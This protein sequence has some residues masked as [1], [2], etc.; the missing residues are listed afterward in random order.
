MS[1]SQV[2]TIKTENEK[3]KKKDTN[4]AREQIIGVFVACLP[5]LCD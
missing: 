2:G 1:Q 4:S 5:V 3:T